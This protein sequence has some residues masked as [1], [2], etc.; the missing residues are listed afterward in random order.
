MR[1]EPVISRDI[2]GRDALTNVMTDGDAM[3]RHLRVQRTL[4]H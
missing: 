3:K 4:H 2:K 1:K